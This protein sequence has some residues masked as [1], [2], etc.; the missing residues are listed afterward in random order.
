MNLGT[1]DSMISHEVQRSLAEVP[2]VVPGSG[3]VFGGGKMRRMRDTL[4]GFLKQHPNLK[5]TKKQPRNKQQWEVSPQK[6]LYNVRG[7][8]F[9]CDRFFL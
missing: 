7:S 9:L 8:F 1:L 2:L 5:T 3:R 6:M 4:E